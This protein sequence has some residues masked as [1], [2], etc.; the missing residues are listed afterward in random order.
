ML[1]LINIIAGLIL[2]YGL[3]ACRNRPAFL[4]MHFLLVVCFVVLPGCWSD[5]PEDEADLTIGDVWVEDEP[6][7][8][9]APT[10]LHVRIVNRGDGPA[11]PSVLRIAVNGV[12]VTTVE[13]DRLGND[14][15]HEY[16]I[17][18]VFASGSQQLQVFVDATGTVDETDET[19][20]TFLIT[21]VGIGMFRAG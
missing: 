17:P 11:K 1:L 16:T 3:W 12:T 21:V 18:M 8:G 2:S 10:A 13:V 20:N 9:E 4:S 7:I 6:V 19:N 15:E 14:S 5:D